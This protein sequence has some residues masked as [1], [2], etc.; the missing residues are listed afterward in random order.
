VTWGILSV[1]IYLI[2]FVV[3]PIG[4]ARLVGKLMKAGS[5]DPVEEKI[6]SFGSVHIAYYPAKN[7]YVRLWCVTAFY[8]VAWTFSHPRLLVGTFSGWSDLLGSLLG[9]WIAIVL[10]GNFVPLIRYLVSLIKKKKVP[11]TT[12]YRSFRNSV[13][14]IVICAVISRL[15]IYGII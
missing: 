8:S 7:R 1:L 9:S 12:M 14:F 10:M 2:I 5:P 6:I 11:E 13:L 15:R 4:L 3:V